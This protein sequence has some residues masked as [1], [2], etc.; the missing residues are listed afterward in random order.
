[1][2]LSLGFSESSLWQHALFSL[3]AHT[4]EEVCGFCKQCFS[5]KVGVMERGGEQV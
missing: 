5:A 1:M 3:I 4:N 2:V